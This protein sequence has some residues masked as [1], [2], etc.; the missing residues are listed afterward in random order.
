M[1]TDIPHAPIVF[2]DIDGVLNSS[3]FF[4]Q[5]PD[6][7]DTEAGAIDPA[8]V[9]RLNRLLASTGAVVVVSSSWRYDRT[10]EDLQR[11]LEVRGFV[12]QVVDKTPDITEQSEHG[13]FLRCATRGQ[14]IF[15]WL[16][17]QR[18]PVA[19]GSMVILDDD[20]DIA[21]LSHRHVKTDIFGGGLL[22]VH[23]DRAIE[24]LKSSA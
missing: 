23:V 16:Q 1:P 10:V 13:I 5:S 8:A 3:A 19:F 6:H 20:T 18:V 17:F 22:D 21:P 4:I 2:L 11:L 24:M 7:E 15:A 9:R 14:E 12:G